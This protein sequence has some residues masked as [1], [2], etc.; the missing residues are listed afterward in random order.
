MSADFDTS[1][2]I[3]LATRTRLSLEQNNT[4]ATNTGDPNSTDSS[5]EA[6]EFVAFLLWYIFLV[7]C[8]VVPTCCAYR[9]RRMIE[10]RLALQQANFNR[11]Q[12]SNL[13]ILS[14][15][16]QPHQNTEQLQNERKRIFSEQLKETTMVS[17]STFMMVDGKKKSALRLRLL[18]SVASFPFNYGGRGA[19]PLQFEGHPSNSQALSCL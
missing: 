4:N 18:P 5:R 17:I 13:F 14:N 3:A 8:C 12:Q 7:L 10:H 11:V 2:V 15:L 6:Y 16:Q 9:R 1:A 19:C